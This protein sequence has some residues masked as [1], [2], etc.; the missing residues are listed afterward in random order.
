M[1]LEDPETQ[2]SDAPPSDDVLYGMVSDKRRRYTV[3][4]LKQQGEAVSVRELAEQ[5]AAWEN[6][7]PP[8]D[9]AYQERKRVYVALYQ[10][11][12]PTMAEKGIVD[13]DDAA[14]M[15]A[16]ADG[17]RD[18]E[19][20]LEV[21]PRESVPWSLYYAGLTLANALLVLLAYFDVPPLGDIPDLALSAIVL[22]TYGTSAFVQL[23]YMRRRRIGDPGPPPEI[24]SSD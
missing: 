22:V 9:V 14:G 1:V 15:V 2:E 19:M 10:S 23:Y 6:E 12:L 7:K 3:H 21:V 4:Y 11:H 13:Y 16:L 18:V 8:A 5:V 20:Y 24:E 17:M